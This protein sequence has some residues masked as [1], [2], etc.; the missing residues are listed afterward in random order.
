MTHKIPNACYFQD[1]G[2]YLDTP[3][4]PHTHAYGWL[5]VSICPS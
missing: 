2:V 1:I 4:T 3:S 5:Q